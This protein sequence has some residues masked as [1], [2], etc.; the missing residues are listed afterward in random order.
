MIQIVHPKIPPDDIARMLEGLEL[1]AMWVD[2]HQVD[3]TVLQLIVPAEECEPIL[4]RFEQRFGNMPGFRAV[5][6][7]VEAA[8]PR[9]EKEAEEESP[10]PEAPP[11]KPP[12]AHRI[13]REELYAEIEAGIKINRVF[14]ALTVLSTVVAAIG[15]LRDDLAV[16]IGAMVI[17]PLLTPNV[18]LSLA[19]T[20]GDTKLATRA[21]KTLASGVGVSLAIALG[22]GII[23]TVDPQVPA[24][25]SR[26]N[27]L[28][29]DLALAFAAGSAGAFVVT[30]GLSAALIGVMVAVALLPPASTVGIMLGSGQLHL[31]LGA[32][33]LL[34]VNIVCVNLA[35]KLVF[36]VK[37]IRPRTWWQKEKA[38]QSMTTYLV[39]W[40]FSLLFLLFAIYVWQGV[41]L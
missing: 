40:V 21:L 8:I 36:L 13:S 31:A 10:S 32:G 6:L 29:S 41:P 33:L 38:R 5:L 23:F 24:V 34:A 2:Q 1:T 19:T 17:A 15:L 4:D 20:L 18:A 11:E 35:A 27:I 25:V 7:E 22:F 28:I 30:T 3:G 26:T 14:L 9:T 39:I 37:G 16:I 12:L